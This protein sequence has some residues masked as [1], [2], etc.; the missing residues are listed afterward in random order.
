MA[1]I[2]DFET[3][4]QEIAARF[5]G[6]STQLQKAARYVLD[7]PDDVAL[8]SMR[9]LAAKADIHPSTMV[10]L[11]RTFGFESYN[12]FRERYQER[13]RLRPES[14]LDRA[15]DLQERTHGET[16]TLFTDMLEADIANLHQ[17]F[18]ANGV[19]T[20]E[21]CAK[22]LSSAKRIF[23]IGLRSCYPI[24]YFFHYA[25]RMFRNDIILLDGQGGALADDLRS[26]GPGDV[27]FCISIEPYSHETVRAVDFALD[28]GGK[29]VVLTD[30]VVSPLAQ[31]AEKVLI[32]SKETPSF[33]DSIS[34]GIAAVETLIGF[35]VAE[36]G[37]DAL[38]AIE[39]SEK[40]LDSFNAYWHE[41]PSP[42]RPKGG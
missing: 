13:L 35:M 34:A 9:Q 1:P 24:A 29:V 21:A 8:V 31:S 26:F 17:T 42:H 2:M 3:L 36:G 30:S 27:L 39:E 32:I 22:N 23:V 25:G 6:L 41:K 40:Q 33:F 10:R 18:E 19:D 15:R 12:D 5:A 20:F 16:G 11:A 4:N 14:F 38:L 7:R 28:H 37:K